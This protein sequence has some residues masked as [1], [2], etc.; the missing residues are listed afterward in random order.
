MVFGEMVVGHCDLFSPFIYKCTVDEAEE[1]LLDNVKG[2]KQIYNII[3]TFLREFESYKKQHD[4][5]WP[6]LGEITISQYQKYHNT[7]CVSLQN[8]A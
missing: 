3:G 7:L 4:N 2:Y 5:L 1:A 8:F 6:E